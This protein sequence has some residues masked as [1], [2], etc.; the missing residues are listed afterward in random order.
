MLVSS[1]LFTIAMKLKRNKGKL[2]TFVVRCVGESTHQANEFTKSH[3]NRMGVSYCEVYWGNKQWRISF[4]SGNCSNKGIW[5]DDISM[6]EI[7]DL[8][9][10]ITSSGAIK[11]TSVL[12]GI[13]KVPGVI[14]G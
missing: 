10:F 13:V 7:L 4:R 8:T 14:T 9:V 11:F 1:W 5:R 6:G 2:I 3:T 12:S